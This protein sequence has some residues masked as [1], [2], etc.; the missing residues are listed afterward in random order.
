[1]TEKISYPINEEI[2]TKEKCFLKVKDVNKKKV[3]KTLLWNAQFENK[4]S[5]IQLQRA[6]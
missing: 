6:M 5:L 1:M 4:K 2:E 3:V